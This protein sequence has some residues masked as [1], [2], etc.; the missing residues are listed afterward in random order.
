MES[1]RLLRTLLIFNSVLW[2]AKIY[3]YA[4]YPSAPTKVLNWFLAPTKVLNW[5]LATDY[6]YLAMF[7]TH[8]LAGVVNL[9]MKDH[10]KWLG[11]IE[12]VMAALLALTVVGVSH[13]AG[14]M[15]PEPVTCL[16]ASIFVLFRHRG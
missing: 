4:A 10:F 2:L 6:L 9:I 16:A 12:M 5:F 14:I 11:E 3:A 15:N 1:V 8:V 7:I 13:A